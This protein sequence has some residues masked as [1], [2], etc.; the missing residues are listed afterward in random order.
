MLK[1]LC[2][3]RGAGARKRK[4]RMPGVRLK[5]AEK[6]RVGLRRGNSPQAARQKLRMR[7][8]GAPRVLRTLPLRAQ[9]LNKMTLNGVKFAK[10]FAAAFASALLCGCAGSES[11][12]KI[13]RAPATSQT[14]TLS[15]KKLL[16]IVAAQNR[17]LEKIRGT[18]SLSV[19]KNSDLLSEKRRI[20]SLWNEYFTGEKRDAESF[21][22]YGKYLRETSNSTAAYKAFLAADA[23][24][25]TLASVKHQL[26]VYESE[27]GQFPEAYAHFLDALKLEPENNVYISQTAK[28]LMVART[29]LAASGKFDIAQLDKKMLEC[30]RKWADSSAPNSQAKWECAKAF[31]SVSHP[32]WEEAL[33]R[34]EDII[35]NSAL[36]LERQ[37]A[38]ANKAR[39]L[40]E[41]R[42]DDQAREILAKVVNEHLAEDKAKLLGVIESDAKNKTQ[43]ESK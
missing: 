17:F 6:T 34:W 23:L 32:D 35:K 12:A 33:S 22:I 10:L 25:P 41:L 29:E 36:E 27:N 21:A 26:A 3:F 5:T 18:K 40:I 37:T 1:V 11:G 19:M 31:Y 9:P 20:D 8:R 43:S 39:V 13:P 16:E 2:R 38:L 28:F 42:R 30:Y 15:Q 7:L 4:A 24:D 14:Y